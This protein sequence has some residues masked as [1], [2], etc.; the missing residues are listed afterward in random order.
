MVG[1]SHQQC[2]QLAFNLCD[3][4]T[5]NPNSVS[6]MAVLESGVAGRRG[7]ERVFLPNN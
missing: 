7:K 6:V 1:Y 5:Q 2:T 4:V 3:F